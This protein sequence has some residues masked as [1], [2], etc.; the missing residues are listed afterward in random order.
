[1]PSERT[2]IVDRVEGEVAVGEAEAGSALQLPLRLLPAGTHE[3]DVLR[4]EGQPERND[5]NAVL[6]RDDA[7]TLERG[8]DISAR[9]QTLR[10]RDP[11]GDIKLCV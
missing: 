2:W 10:R 1:M 4:V 3:G 7:A 6:R 11:G 9:L 8:R 5:P